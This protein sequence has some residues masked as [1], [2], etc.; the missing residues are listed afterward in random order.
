M[1]CKY[2]VTIVWNNSLGIE[3]H[4]DQKVWFD[5]LEG[6]FAFPRLCQNCAY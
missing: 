1:E 3:F 2:V 5:L 4:F 6:M